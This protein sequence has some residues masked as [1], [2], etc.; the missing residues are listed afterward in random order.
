MA[1]SRA[2]VPAQVLG[3]GDG[4]FSLQEQP[5]GMYRFRLGEDFAFEDGF[6]AGKDLIPVHDQV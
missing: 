1:L 6:D 5:G 4:F 3:D 2:W